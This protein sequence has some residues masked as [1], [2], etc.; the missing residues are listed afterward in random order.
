MRL[1]AEP[2]RLAPSTSLSLPKGHASKPQEHALE[3]MARA[4]APHM[5]RATPSF[6]FAS[7]VQIGAAH[8]PRPPPRAAAVHDDGDGAEEDAPF[9]PALLA[10]LTSGG[11]MPDSRELLKIDVQNAHQVLRQLLPPSTTFTLSDAVRQTLVYQELVENPPRQK[12]DIYARYRFHFPHMGTLL[13][14]Q[15][16]Q[17]SNA[18]E[19]A[20]LLA[21]LLISGKRPATRID[22]FTFIDDLHV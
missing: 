16:L 2:L 8:Q 12:P 9:S 13:A 15:P 6:S 10:F 14:R 18:R 11:A 22:L 3:A 5:R 19:R 7:T 4:L 21:F 20:H 17:I 1:K